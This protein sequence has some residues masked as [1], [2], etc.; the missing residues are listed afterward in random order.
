MAYRN[1][2][3]SNSNKFNKYMSKGHLSQAWLGFVSR[4]H[5]DTPFLIGLQ[6]YIILIRIHGAYAL[7]SYE[8]FFPSIFH[9]VKVHPINEANMDSHNNFYFSR[10][11]PK[12]HIHIIMIQDIHALVLQE[13]LLIPPFSSKSKFIHQIGGTWVLMI[14]SIFFMIRH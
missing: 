13:K 12:K 6:K 1:K 8:K 4:P 7:V 3:I 9:R 2:R 10:D 5:C 11:W 14:I